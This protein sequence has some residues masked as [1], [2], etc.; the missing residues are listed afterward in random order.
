MFAA[1]NGV[2]A[3][4]I[5]PVKFPAGEAL[6]RLQPKRAPEATF[7]SGVLFEYNTVWM[8]QREQTSGESTRHGFIEK[9]AEGAE[10]HLR[11][12]RFS[13]N[14][15]VALEDVET[16]AR[17]YEKIFGRKNSQGI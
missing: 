2:T 15:P 9:T 13:Q 16:T 11:P 10:N 12:G 14:P 4:G 1:S 7:S 5:A 8:Q 17:K 3:G 6:A